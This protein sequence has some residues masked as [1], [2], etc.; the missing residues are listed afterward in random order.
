[1]NIDSVITVNTQPINPPVNPF[2]EEQIHND[3]AYVGD[4]SLIATYRV[5]YQWTVR[6]GYQLLYVDG[7]ALATDNFNIEPPAGPFGPFG[8]RVPFVDDDG[9]AFYHGLFVG[10]EYMW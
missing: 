2:T 8:A 10:A 4:A 5:N 6:G 1:M 3:V 9:S 7:V